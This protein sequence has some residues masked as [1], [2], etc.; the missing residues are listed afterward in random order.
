MISDAP[1][2][3]LGKWRCPVDREIKSVDGLLFP[4]GGT[5]FG[6]IECDTTRRMQLKQERTVIEFVAAGVDVVAVANQEKVFNN[7]F[8]VKED[9]VVKCCHVGP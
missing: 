1:S 7:R 5:G 4:G 3:G 6:R 8:Y 9:R 2:W